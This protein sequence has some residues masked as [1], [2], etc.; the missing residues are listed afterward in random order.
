M[1]NCDT[2]ENTGIMQE[3]CDNCSGSGEGQYDGSTCIICKGSGEREME[4][5]ECE[6]TL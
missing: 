5:T 1:E 2:C 3:L 4:C 6:R